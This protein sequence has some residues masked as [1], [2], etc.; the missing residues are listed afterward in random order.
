[1]ERLFPKRVA[2][3]QKN[4]SMYPRAIDYWAEIAG[5]LDRDIEFQLG[6]GLMIAETRE[7]LEALHAKSAVEN[8]CGIETSMLG[9]TETLTIAPYLNADIVAGALYCPK[10]G[11]ANPLT[12]T[13]E[14]RRKAVASGARLIGDAHVTR[15][16]SAARGHLVES[17]RGTFRADRVVVAA[18]AG[19]G[20]ILSTLG[21]EIPVAAEALH[22]NVT[23]A[24]GTIMPHLVQ[25]AELALTMKQL[26][27]GQLLIG[28]GWPAG[29]SGE[30]RTPEVLSDSLLGNL[31]LARRLVPGVADLEVLRTWAGINTMVDLTSVLGEIDGLSG[32]FIAIPGDAGFTL[33]PYC[34]RLV[35]EQMAGRS[36]D[37]PLEP[38]SPARFAHPLRGQNARQ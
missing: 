14:V 13:N 23:E 12:A 32:M 29:Y 16:E 19:S 6:G 37:Y 22:M 38:F 26:K 17:S 20:D 24:T 36:P 31:A 1:M 15:V 21:V 28:G 34:A 11:K 5:Q 9:A 18:G 33:A 30:L 7:H 4:L 10:E 35:V 2:D 27:T 8:G 25:H 3:Y